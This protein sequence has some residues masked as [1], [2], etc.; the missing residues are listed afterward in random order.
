[1]SA[2]LSPVVLVSTE[3]SDGFSRREFLRRGAVAGVALALPGSLGCSGGQTRRDGPKVVIVGAGLA[4]LSCAYRLAQGG[5]SSSLFEAN[6]S[7][8]GGRCWTARGFAGGQTAEHGGEFIDSRHRR[9]RALA[10]EFGLELND[11][12]AVSDPGSSRW[13]LNDRRRRAIRGRPDWRQFERALTAAARRAGPFRFDRATPAARAMDEMTAAQWMDVNLTGGSAGL[14]GQLV[15]AEMAS[16]FGLDADRLSALNLIVQYLVPAPGADER[17]TIRGGNDQLVEGLAAALPDGTI[18]R[19]APLEVLRRRRRGG[20]Y[21]LRFAGIDREA[22]ADHVVLALPFSTLREVDLGRAGLSR[23][24]LACIDQLGMGTNAKLLMQFDRRPRRYGDWSGYLTS[25]S[26]YLLTWES[27]LGQPGR[28]SI[29]TT[30]FGGRSGAAGLAASGAHAPTV[31]GEVGRN[32]GSLTED[33]GTGI[34]GL[35]RGFNGKAW[36]D[37]WVS[38]RWAR[39]SYAA[40]LPGQLTRYYG[41]A[42]RSEGRI[43]FAGEH[44]VVADQGYLEGAVRSGERAA[45]TILA[46]AR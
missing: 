13:W 42:G 9:I 23:K 24:R 37:R 30:F 14:V 6:P 45:A 22:V 35:G 20:G 18:R 17:Y 32:L 21:G 4:G 28:S 31:P 27:T 44:T 36:T 41:Y 46:T 38:D 33:G 7:R 12:F 3:V 39:G 16:E 2:E 11:T 5:L 26:P 10:R 8:L 19:D 25:D 43:H 34:T 40:F 29:I 15:W 1:M